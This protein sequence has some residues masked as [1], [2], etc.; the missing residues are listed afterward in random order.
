MTP[1]R[2]REEGRTVAHPYMASALADQQEEMLAR[3][4]ATSVEELFEQIPDGHRLAGPVRLPP[5]LASEAALRRHLQGI[6]A[7]TVSTEEA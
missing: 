2:H 4:G 1:A 3:I 7:R 6:L 5:Q